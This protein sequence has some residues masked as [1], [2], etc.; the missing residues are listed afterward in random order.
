MFFWL[1]SLLAPE[2]ITAPS[3]TI[4]TLFWTSILEPPILAR[5]VRFLSSFLPSF[6]F[7]FF[8]TRFQV[9]INLG[10]LKG[11]SAYPLAAGV[12]ARRLCN[13]IM[14]RSVL[15][16]QPVAIAAL[17]FFALLCLVSLGE[18]LKVLASSSI[19]HGRAHTT[20][21]TVKRSWESE[22]GPFSPPRPEE[23]LDDGTEELNS[24]ADN[25]PDIDEKFGLPGLSLPNPLATAVSAVGCWFHG[26]S[27]DIP[28]VVPG[29]PTQPPVPASTAASGG[30]LFPSVLSILAGSPGATPAPDSPGGS[31]P[32]G[33]LLSALSQAAPSP[34][35]PGPAITAPPA[36]PTGSS[37]FLPGL[38]VLDGVASALNGVLGSPDESDSGGIGLLGQ[39][40]ANI[41]DPIASIAA[42]PASVL[43]NPSAAMSNLQSQVSNVLNSM[44]SAVAAG[45]QLAS[46]VGGDLADALNAT[47]NMLDSA[48]DVAGGV[49]GQV[50]SLLN[51][52][53]NLATGI[54]SA[55]L[56]AV[57]QVGA[58]LNGVPGVGDEV[59]GILGGLKNDL[60]N[61]VASAAPEVSALAGVVQSQVVGVL[62]SALQPLVSGALSS[63]ATAP[64]TENLPP[65]PGQ[66]PTS[67]PKLASLL[68][69]LSSSIASAD[70]AAAVT[71]SAAMNSIASSALSGLSSLMSQISQLSL[72]VATASPSAPVPS[73][74]TGE[75]GSW[76]ILSQGN[77]GC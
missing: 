70:P 17:T 37:G 65:V 67:S 53:P 13:H 15:L 22:Q 58:I 63:L 41:L 28:G 16:S 55:A 73:S 76:L 23:L 44:P 61:A 71:G 4:T 59:A 51:A 43:A 68:S 19:L 38:S 56:D 69:S 26:C 31:A 62:P 75:S 54:P 64:A 1:V 27:S 72:T 48:P 42:D 74:A 52:A 47:T 33:G 57:N 66:A 29:N 2:P 5:S 11:G 24:D 21:A 50:G 14:Q 49:A 39:L 3:T 10:G 32:L 6:L 35:P 30:G 60:S 40:S 9:H 20:N 25:V 18:S 12:S 45:V 46:N 36:A 34:N 77:M 8:V 7:F